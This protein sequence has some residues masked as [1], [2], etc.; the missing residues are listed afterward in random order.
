MLK[1]CTRQLTT[2]KM[3]LLR[4]DPG[5]WMAFLGYL[6]QQ[7]DKFTDRAGARR[8]FAEGAAAA[9]RRDIASLESVVQQLLRMLPP[10][11]ANSVKSGFGS[12]VM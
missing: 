2:V 8:L 4:K 1:H 7:Q 10:D 5:F 12:D 6:Q 9:Q 3:Q 11:V